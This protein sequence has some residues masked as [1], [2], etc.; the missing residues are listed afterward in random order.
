MQIALQLIS[1]PNLTVPVWRERGVD[2]RVLDVL[3]TEVVLD[4]ADIA[5]LLGQREAAGMPQLVRMGMR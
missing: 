5:A 4:L 3:V 2:R 1:L